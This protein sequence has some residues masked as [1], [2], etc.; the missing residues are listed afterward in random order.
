[1]ITDAR[2]LQPEFIPTEVKHR[3]AELNTLSAALNP[4]TH[5]KPADATFLFGPS[6]VG[7]TCLAKFIVEQLR[8]TVVDLNYQYV[9]CWEDYSRFKTL[10]R[11]L[12]G[13]NH[14]FDVH[15]QS[16]PKDVLLE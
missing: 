15:R 7:K 8:E 12:D 4:I 11:I 10:Y 1:M 5:E 2:V 13:V 9:N 6:G 14:T 16:T 3:D